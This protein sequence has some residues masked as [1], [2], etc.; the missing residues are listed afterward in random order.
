MG[1]RV[2]NK[3]V[4]RRQF[5]GALIGVLTFVVLAVGSAGQSDAFRTRLELLIVGAMVWALVE[6]VRSR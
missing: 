3:A 4:S 1:F 2:E 6:L 5:Y